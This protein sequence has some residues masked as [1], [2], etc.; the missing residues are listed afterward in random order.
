MTIQTAA[1]C[2]TKSAN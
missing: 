1:D 2:K